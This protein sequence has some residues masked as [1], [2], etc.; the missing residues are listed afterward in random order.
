MPIVQAELIL[1]LPRTNSK[2]TLRVDAKDLFNIVPSILHEPLRASRYF[3]KSSN[4]LVIQSD[5]SRKQVDN[6][7]NCYKK[8]QDLIVTT[9]KGL[10]RGE[11]SFYQMEKVQKL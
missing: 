5:V 8:L 7:Q 2:A 11:T 3:A 6:V 9:G 4:S 10:V 1:T